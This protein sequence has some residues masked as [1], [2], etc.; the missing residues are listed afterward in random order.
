VFLSGKDLY[1]VAGA[2]PGGLALDM[3]ERAPLVLKSR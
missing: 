1:L 3:F 2:K